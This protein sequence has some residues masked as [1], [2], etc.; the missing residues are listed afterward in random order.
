M[1]IERRKFLVL[2]ASIVKG[3]FLYTLAQS[4]VAHGQVLLY[5]SA[6]EN[7]QGGFE[8]VCFPP[9]GTSTSKIMLPDRGHSITMRPNET[10]AILFAR[11]PGTFAIAFHP[12]TGR[13]IQSLG[14]HQGRCFC[15]HG[16]FEPEGRLVYATENDFE[17][18]RGVIGV[19]DANENYRRIKEIPS[20]GIGPHEIKLYPDGQTL[21]V[22]NGGILT[23]PELPRVKMNL[24]TME[25]SLCY[26]NR[27]NGKLLAKFSL[28]E[29]F[30]QL[31]IRHIDINSAGI[32]GIAMQYKGPSGNLVP[33]IGMHDG[34]RQIMLIDE[35]HSVIRSMKNY[36]GSIAFDSSGEV[37]A[38]S[39]PLGGC[40]T[41]WDTTAPDF[42]SSVNIK[43]VC[44]ISPSTNNGE[45]LVSGRGTLAFVQARSGQKELLALAAYDDIQWDNHLSVG[46][47][48]T[49]PQI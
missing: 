7:Q 39:S 19:Y 17:N 26:I 45:F 20:H 1:V 16:V 35:P 15:G 48:T 25:S 30:R 12:G 47:G 13:L 36:C 6:C 3:S 10:E 11:R 33:L 22:A 9:D 8:V 42:L 41:F 31:S 43:D 5:A 44:G 32:V 49:Q 4:K 29:Q 27:E 14:S 28:T 2:V 40:V 18:G 21:V 37:L 46:V 34:S 23:H 38:V 24:P